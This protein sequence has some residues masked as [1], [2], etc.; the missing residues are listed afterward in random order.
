MGMMDKINQKMG[1]E[2]IKLASE[3]FER[4]WQMRQENKSPNYTTS[5]GDILSV[6]G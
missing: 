1:R 6:Q 2:S 3:G 5:W 4:P